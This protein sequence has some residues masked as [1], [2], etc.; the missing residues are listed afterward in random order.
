LADRLQ[1]LE[2]Q[3]AQVQEWCASKTGP[4]AA[5]LDEVIEPEPSKNAS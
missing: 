4:L 5:M 3:V 2:R 1:S